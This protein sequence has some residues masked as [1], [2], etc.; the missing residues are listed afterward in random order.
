MKVALLADTDG[1]WKWAARLAA[2]LAAEPEIL[3][4][5]LWTHELPSH[6]QLLEA[7][8][9]PEQVRQLTPSGL[10]EAL[11]TDLPDIL[12]VAAPGGGCQAVLQLLAAARLEPR[13]LVLTGYVGVVYENPVDGLLLRAGSDLIGVNSPADLEQFAGV[14]TSV[15]ARPESLVRTQLP[16]LEDP[17]PR[18]PSG[19]F[20]VTFAGQPGV[21]TSRAER[22]HLVQRLADHARRHPERDVLVKLRNVPG[23]LATHPEPYPYD[24]LIR[25]LGSQRPANLKVIG[26]LMSRAL[27]RTDLLVTVSSMAAVEAIHA[28]VAAAVLT[29]FGIRESLGNTYFLGSGLLAGFDELDRG[30]VPTVNLDWARQRGVRE[31]HD[32]LP[33]R[34][35]Q[36]LAEPRGELVPFYNLTNASGLLPRLLA[37]YGVGPDGRPLPARTTSVLRKAVRS[38]ARGVYRH[39]TTVIGPALRRLAAL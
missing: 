14:L 5:Q 30:L 1:R 39:G 21:P 26:G 13:P 17:A 38:G 22:Q 31:L 4:Y 15:G 28:G 29:D 36:A 7:G 24:E 19:R 37:G 25:G 9:R 35:V 10:L 32:D 6:R 11:A 34:V 8:V 18:T 33:G 23:E 2:R 12:V 3:G 20:A 16:F 27:S